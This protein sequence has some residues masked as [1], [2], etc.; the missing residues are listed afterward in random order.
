VAS[1]DLR[2]RGVLAEQAAGQLDGGH[3]ARYRVPGGTVA[4]WRGGP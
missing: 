4:P 2:L 3:A 1:D